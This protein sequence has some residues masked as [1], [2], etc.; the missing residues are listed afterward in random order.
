MTLALAVPRPAGARM[1]DPARRAALKQM[2]D[3]YDDA[4]S[5]DGR[6]FGSGF[7]HNESVILQFDQKTWTPKYQE[8]ERCL[9]ELRTLAHGRRPMI[10]KGVSSSAAWWH[11]AER[12]LRCRTER[13]ELHT[14]K[15]RA[16]HRVPQGIGKNM[17]VL[18]RPTLL[19]GSRVAV[20]LRVW[21][22]GVREEIVDAAVDWIGER[23]VGEP[24]LPKE[25]V[26]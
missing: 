16:G 23:F 6:S 2:L 5:T 17:E 9:I 7:Q 25:M 12:Y 24:A 11:L 13:R 10:A 4:R 8:L 1:T 19:H 15:T 14:R 26:A 18:S 20:V 22:P 3:R 21:H